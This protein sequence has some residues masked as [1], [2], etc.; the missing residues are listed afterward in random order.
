MYNEILVGPQSLSDSARTVAR[1]GKQ[2]EQIVSQLNGPL[3]E[4]AVRQNLFNAYA[5]VT[6]PVI[7]STAA[8]TGGPLLWNG[9]N[10]VNAVL[11][12]VGYSVSVVTTVAGSIGITGGIGQTAA[13]TS[14]TAID[15]GPR[16]HYLGGK[17]PLCS[18]Y[19]VGT[20]TNAGN[21]FL[22]FAYMHTGALTTTSNGMAWIDLDGSIVVPPQGWASVA[23]SATLTTLQVQVAL[24]WAEVPI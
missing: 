9:S 6:A 15:A 8:G 18:T 13:P 3:Y 21:F 11:L 22:P 23:G 20:P 17:A 5:T 2:G 14:T 19:R 4:Q 7:Y 16:N 10:T 24:V 1:G 12:K